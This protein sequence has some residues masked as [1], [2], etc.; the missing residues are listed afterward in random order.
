MSPHLHVVPSPAS[1]LTAEQL[2]ARIKERGGRPYPMRSGDVF[3]LTDNQEVADWLLDLGG[4]PYKA[5]GMSM[6]MEGGYLRARDGKREWDVW[7][8]TI[9]VT[10]PSVW[11]TLHADA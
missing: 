9:P 2:L 8:H 6:G 5:S 3:V 11:E 1:A 10:G 7:I 4:H